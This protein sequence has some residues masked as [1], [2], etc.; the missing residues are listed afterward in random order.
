MPLS[1]LE[2]AEHWR[3]R[4]EQARNVADSLSERRAGP[5]GTPAKAQE[6]KMA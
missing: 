1:L 6:L 4:A 2:D 5:P 3:R